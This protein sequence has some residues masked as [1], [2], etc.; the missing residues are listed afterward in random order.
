LTAC[1]T[2]GGASVTRSYR[3]RNR[4]GTLASYSIASK[5]D[6]TG[7][8]LPGFLRLLAKLAFWNYLPTRR[9]ASF[10]NVWAGAGKPDSAKREAVRK[11]RRSHR[12]DRRPLPAGRGGRGHG[13]G[14]VL[15]PD[16]PRQ[17]HPGALTAPPPRDPA[18]SRTRRQAFRSV[19]HHCRPSLVAS[20]VTSS[21]R[22]RTGL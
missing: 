11:R 9:H 4:T 13:T 18:L 20:A 8:V 10:Y 1:S 7:P 21:T 15:R 5:L 2:L 22:R 14:L 6:D 19:M 16:R 17:D 3:L 12:E